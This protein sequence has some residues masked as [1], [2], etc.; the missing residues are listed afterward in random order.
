MKDLIDLRKEMKKLLDNTKYKVLLQRTSKKI[1]CS[2]Y[3][4]KYHEGK[5]HCNKCLGTGYLF[6]FEKQ[7][8]FKQDYASSPDSAILFTEIG[9][10]SYNTRT[11]Y[12]SH[13][14][15]PQAKDYIWEVSWKG[16]KPIELKNLYRI[17]SVGE[18]RGVNGRIEFYVVVA[19]LEVLDKDFRNNYIGKAWRDN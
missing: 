1:H 17:K 8:T 7:K 9:Q 16:E 13:D 2:C 11:F 10:F 4:D 14:S 18:Q 15:N 12:F 3:N 5:A 6:K 19:E